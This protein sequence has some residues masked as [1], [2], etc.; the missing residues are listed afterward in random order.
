VRVFAGRLAEM[1]D[2]ECIAVGDGRAIVVRVGSELR[3]FRN[4]CVHQESPLA[5]GWVRNGVLTCPLHFW[6]YRIDDGTHL[7]STSKLER[8]AVDVVDGDVF[9][10]MPDEASSLSLRD[11]LLARARVYD[12]DEAWRS[13]TGHAAD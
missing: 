10:L 2:R 7:G 9:V 4:R 3:A 6:R 5:G 1:S 8:F 12:R 13:E 11:Q